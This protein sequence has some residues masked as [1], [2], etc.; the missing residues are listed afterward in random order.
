MPVTVKQVQTT[1]PSVYAFDVPG[2]VTEEDLEYMAAR[3]QAAFDT[4]DKVNL[5]LNFENYQGNELGALADA[6]VVKTH[7]SALSNLD[8]YAVVGAPGHMDAM[9][10][11]LS[12]V[13]PVK[14]ETF[15]KGEAAAAWAHVGAR[16]AASAA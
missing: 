3:M 12:V 9:L 2:E 7:F 4:R 8:R 1:E 14:A 10:E 16:P 11:A 13:I 6:D 5:L 15:D